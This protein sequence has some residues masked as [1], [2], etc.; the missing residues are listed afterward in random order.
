MKLAAIQLDSIPTDVRGNVARGMTWC[1]RALDNGA[2]MVFL[3]EGL[4]ADYAAEPLRVARPLKSVEVYSF[5]ELAS[6]YDAVIAL[7]LN[8]LW[9]GQAYISCAYLADGEVV[10][11]YRKSFL[12]SL[13]NPH[14]RIPYIDGFRQELGVIGHGDGTRIVQVRGLTIGTIICADGNTD[15]AWQTFRVSRPDLVFFQN[16]RSCVDEQRNQAFAQEI[17]RPMIVTNRV[18]F[19]YY[20]FQLGGSRIIRRDGSIAVA[21]N[22]DGIPQIIY[23]DFADL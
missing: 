3:H 10:D 17:Q 8:E 16:N 12:W 13:P 22:C 23:A 11:V 14:D 7:G 21:A 19:S 4:T 18:G 1:K 5:I 9:N 6:R 2:K 20:H 15:A